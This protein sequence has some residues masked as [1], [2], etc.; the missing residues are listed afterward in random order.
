MSETDKASLDKTS[1]SYYAKKLYLN[2]E[3]DKT[4]HMNQVGGLLALDY[5]LNPNWQ[6][7]YKASTGFLAPSTSQMYSAF[8]MLGNRLTTNVNLKPEKSLNHELSLQGSFEKGSLNATAFYT[9]YKDFINTVYSEES[10]KICYDYWGVEVCDNRIINFIKAGNIDRAKTY[11]VR[12]GGIWDVSNLLKNTG[13][14]KVTGDVSLAK[15]STSDGTNLLAT[16][17]PTGIFGL[18]YTTPDNTLDLHAKVRYLGAKKPKDAK[19]KDYIFQYGD[20]SKEVIA[21]YEH[22]NASKTAVVYDLYGTKSLSNGLSL[23]AGIYN[24]FDKKYTP[25]SNLRSLAELNVNSMVDDEGQGLARYTAPG[26]NYAVSLSY[27]F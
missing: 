25:W 3:F 20:F 1:D 14:L 22:I 2:G 16:N 5:Q 15:D 6:L 21:P 19:V 4:N 8:E 7:G 24:I 27:A 9:D 10:E 17:P 13:T 12:L 23:S 18:D 26:R 11:G